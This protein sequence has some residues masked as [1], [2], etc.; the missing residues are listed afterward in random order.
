MKMKMA[1]FVLASAVL[2][3]F[4]A[5]GFAASL[6][7]T[8]AADDTGAPLVHAIVF[9]C[10][11]SP[12]CEGCYVCTGTGTDEAGG[13]SIT[14][15]EANTYYVEYSYAGGE[16][17]PSDKYLGQYYNNVPN[18]DFANRTQLT[19]AEG[20]AL[21]LETARL[22]VRPF[23]METQAAPTPVILPEEGGDVTVTVT[24]VNT[25]G[26]KARLSFFNT[27]FTNRLD[28]TDYYGLTYYGPF[29]AKES[30]ILKPGSNTFIFRKT[31]DKA[32]SQGYYVF[33][34]VAGRSPALAMTGSVVG[35]FCKEGPDID[36]SPAEVSA[37]AARAAEATKPR[38]DRATAS[39]KVRLKI[40]PEGRI[41]DRTPLLK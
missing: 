1:L 23:Y 16:T 38:A 41:L 30:K 11:A 31:V 3:A 14:D 25:T 29:F 33:I 36:C 40:S 20:D 13:F 6:S 15:L 35:A 9:A 5:N 28:R 17:E 34:I 21:S 19:L 22:R 18:Y 27:L 2:L 12:D 37:A 32:A 39:G 7:G 26:K 24:V 8:V 4:S 10:G